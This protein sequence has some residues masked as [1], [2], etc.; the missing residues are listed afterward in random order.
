MAW[1]Y[2]MTFG[3]LIAFNA[4][5]LLLARTSATLASSYT[6]VNPL[7]ALLL[8]VTLGRESVSPYE[9]AAAA[10]VMSGVVLLFLGRRR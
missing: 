3:S 9:W 7:V 10:V 2:L 4:Y 6:L 8:G 1:A 5:M